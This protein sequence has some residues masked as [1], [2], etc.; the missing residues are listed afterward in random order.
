MHELG[1]KEV[2]ET[3]LKITNSRYEFDFFLLCVYSFDSK[4]WLSF[5]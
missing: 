4:I 3:K 1:A 2:K 5:I